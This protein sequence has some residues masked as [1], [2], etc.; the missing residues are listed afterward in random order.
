MVQTGALEPILLTKGD[1]FSLSLA[2][3]EDS[4]QATP[5][6]LEQYTEIKMQIRTAP[7]ASTGNLI[8]TAS[9]GAGI[10]VMGADHNVL[11]INVP[12]ATEQVGRYY[13]DI[14]MKTSA[15]VIATPL[16]GVIVI[17]A[18]VTEL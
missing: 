9:L 11:D 2:F 10:S 7:S 5:L 1:T 12:L 16:T 4:E 15:N 18:N 17:N 3:F 13:F 14:R 6:N 8:A